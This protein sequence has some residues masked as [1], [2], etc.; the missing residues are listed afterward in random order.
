MCELFLDD[1]LGPKR[2]GI[3]LQGGEDGHVAGG[4]ILEVVI[5]RGAVALGG[6]AVGSV[7]KALT[8]Q[9]QRYKTDIQIVSK[10]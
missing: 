1:N 10:L 9:L 5:T 8:V 6:T 4:L 2:I 7:G 3:P